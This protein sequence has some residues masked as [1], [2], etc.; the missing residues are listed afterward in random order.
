MKIYP[1]VSPSVLS[2]F[3]YL[4][5]NQSQPAKT[6]QPDQYAQTTPLSHLS[7]FTP[8]SLTSPPRSPHALFLGT[9]RRGLLLLFYSRLIQRYANL[10]QGLR[11]RMKH[12]LL[13]LATFELPSKLHLRR[14]LF[15]GDLRL[16]HPKME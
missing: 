6:A 15:V 16:Q 3:P 1:F 4:Y 2:A 11:G 12:T 14:S 10:L 13:A 5:P 7:R 8:L 9:Y